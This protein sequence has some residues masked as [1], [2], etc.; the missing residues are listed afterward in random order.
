MSGGW[1]SGLVDVV[2]AKLP[3][4]LNREWAI[5]ILDA[6]EAEGWDIELRLPPMPAPGQR[7]YHDPEHPCGSVQCSTCYP[8]LGGRYA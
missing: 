8:L 4:G 1:D 2:A 7:T 6:I 3:T 5:E